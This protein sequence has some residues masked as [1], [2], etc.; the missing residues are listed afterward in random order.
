M[1]LYIH[2][3]RIYKQLDKIKRDNIIL[4]CANNCDKN[5]WFYFENILRV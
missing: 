1:Y 4:L 5:K 2:S 3:I